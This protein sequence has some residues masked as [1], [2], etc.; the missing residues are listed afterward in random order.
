[1]MHCLLWQNHRQSMTNASYQSTTSQSRKLVTKPERKVSA[2]L[3]IW[4]IT[5]STTAAIRQNASFAAMTFGC[6]DFFDKPIRAAVFA[7][8]IE[9]A[10][11]NSTG[12][13]HTENLPVCRLLVRKGVKPVEGQH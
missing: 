8:H 3:N 2:P 4:S 13:Q 10:A 5:A 9:A 6:V 12:T 1:M 11:K 7:L